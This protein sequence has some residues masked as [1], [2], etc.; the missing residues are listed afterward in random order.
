MQVSQPSVSTPPLRSS[1]LSTTWAVSTRGWECKKPL[2]MPSWQFWAGTI[3]SSGTLC[4]SVAPIGT[5]RWTPCGSQRREVSLGIPLRLNVG[6][7]R[8]SGA[9]LA[10]AL[11]S[12]PMRSGP[13]LEHPHQVHL[14]QFLRGEAMPLLFFKG[15]C[16]K[17]STPIRRSNFSPPRPFFGHRSCA[18]TPHQDPSILR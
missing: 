6:M 13:G 12:R 14:Q 16:H 2:A 11:T 17:P 15:R 5:Q 1:Q 9:L 18:A 4:S 8:W 10:C 3:H 7:S